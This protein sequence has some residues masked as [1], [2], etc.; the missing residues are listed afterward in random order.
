[1]ADLD[2]L[3]PDCPPKDYQ[4]GDTRIHE[5]T[6]ISRYDSADELTAMVGRLY[7]P[8]A[9]NYVRD[10]NRPTLAWRLQ[11]KYQQVAKPKTG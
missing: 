1:V 3:R 8:V 4:V 7:G 9:E 10:R 6:Y 5:F 11:I 2:L